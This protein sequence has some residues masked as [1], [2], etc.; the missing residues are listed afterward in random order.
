[1]DA[2]EYA[3]IADKIMQIKGRL[4]QSWHQTDALVEK[5]V[6]LIHERLSEALV[7]LD[8]LAKMDDMGWVK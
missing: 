5:Q 2:K 6:D 8:T 7:F 1:M 4:P 3:K